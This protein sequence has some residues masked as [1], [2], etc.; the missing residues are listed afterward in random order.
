[1]DGLSGDFLANFGGCISKG[2]RE[3]LCYYSLRLSYRETELLLN[4]LTGERLYGHRQIA[5]KVAQESEKVKELIDSTYAGMQLSIPFIEKVDIYDSKSREIIYFDDGVGVKKQKEHR[6]RRSA[7][8]EQAKILE[9]ESKKVQTDVVV[10]DSGQKNVHYLTSAEA[11]KDIENSILCQLS[12]QYP[13]QSLPII[14]ITDG[15]R[16]IRTRLINL[17]GNGI[18][19]ILDWYHLEDKVRKYL[20]RLGL[21]KAIKEAHIKEILGYLWHGKAVEALIYTDEMI[22]TKKISIL[23]ELQDYIFKHRSE[24]C[25]YEKRQKFARKVI[26]SGKGEKANDIIVA[27]RQKKKAMAWSKKGA[28]ALTVLKTVDANGLWKLYWDIAA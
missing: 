9:E 2:V 22:D 26:G 10:I 20:S 4:R 19:I 7:K 21:D 17:F 1:M 12:Y 18:Q 3:L 15:A 5:N 24:I 14:A 28:N 27:H 16:C 6:G 13:C 8:K 23:Q 11:K 25:N